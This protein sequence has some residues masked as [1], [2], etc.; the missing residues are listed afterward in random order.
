MNNPAP[1]YQNSS[2]GMSPRQRIEA[3]DAALE[4]RYWDRE[5]ILTLLAERTAEIDAVLRELWQTHL[6]HTDLALYAVGGYGRG[7]M[8]PHSDLDLLIIGDRPDREQTSIEAFVHALYDLG[9]DVGHSVRAENEVASLA[10]ADLTVATSL[11]DRRPLVVNGAVEDALRQALDPAKLWRSDRFY[12]AK[13]AEQRERHD[14]YANTDYGLEPNV[15]ESPG[16]LRDLQTAMWVFQ[17]HYETNDPDQLEARAI[18]T[19]QERDWLV[20]GRRYLLWVRYGLHLVAGRKEDRLQ[21]EH[22]RTLARGLGYVD[23]DAKLGVERFMQLYYRHVLV[24]RELNDIM[25]QV[26]EEQILRSAERTR[27]EPVN[28]RFQLHNGYMEV[29]DEHLFSDNPSAILELFVLLAAHPGIGGVRANTIRAIRANLRL[30]DTEFRNRPEN[31]QLFMQLLR[32]P[33]SVVTQLTRMRRYGVLGRY[34]PEFG[35]IVGQMQ[36]DLF[37]IYTVDA[38]TMEVI[39][40]MRRFRLRSATQTFPIAAHCVRAV[41]RIELLYIAG[42]YHDI[43][44]GRG[45]DHSTLGARDAAAFCARHGLSES[46]SNLVEWLVQN[47]LL[48]SAT[49]QRKDIYDPEVILEFAQTVKSERR[50]NYLYALTVADINA[51]NPTLW[52]H[53]RATLLHQLYAESKRA[54]RRGLEAP[55][56]RAESVADCQAWARE[57]LAQQDVADEAID[58]VWE[59]LGD[60][61]FLRHTPREVAEISG[62]LGQH[63]PT[64]GALVLVRDSTP[65][66]GETASN[67]IYV[68]ME[69]RPGIFS[70][71]ANMLDRERFSI[72]EAKVFTSADG[73]CCNQFVVLDSD[74]NP[75][76]ADAERWQQIAERLA[77]ILDDPASEPS[78]AQRR[79]SRRARQLTRPTEVSLTTERNATSSRLQITASDRPGL[80][81][82]I[83]QLLAELGISII[84]AR[85]ATLGD[86]VE[87]TFEIKDADLRPITDPEAVYQLENHIRQEIDRSVGIANT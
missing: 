63:D 3:F 7:E 43:G 64:D 79:L 41:A 32:S 54:L 21:F 39:R 74:G 12:R 45:G 80:L 47:H 53:W 38:H 49:A 86:R 22:Q 73:R 69:D 62:E 28:D 5:Q 46:D 77:V 17:R 18:L 19:R 65:I 15:K 33:Q 42:L 60:D 82:T 48:M 13:L 83:G 58:A 11:F 36:H 75:I 14:R 8:L 9:L 67:S 37:H 76:A 59:V 6:G 44:K 81:A 31:A 1:A 50:L 72:Y 23:T 66:P 87:D 34:L 20:N 27:I 85:I 61:F 51:T 16:G 52:N 70:T 57:R 29:R 26:F 78:T 30:I 35:R 84:G 55:I 68:Y 4:Q 24:L 25:L 10:E 71:I 56:D 40:N 2:S